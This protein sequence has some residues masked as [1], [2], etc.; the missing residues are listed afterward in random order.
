[1]D[2]CDNFIGQKKTVDKKISNAVE[3]IL[4]AASIHNET[5]VGI[6]TLMITNYVYFNAKVLGRLGFSSDSG[7]SDEYSFNEENK[8]TVLN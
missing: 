2:E 7:A 6:L 8:K 5:N 1:M 3:D 4:N